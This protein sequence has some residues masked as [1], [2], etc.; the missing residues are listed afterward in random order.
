V[1]QE[2]YKCVTK[3]V[4]SCYKRVTRVLQVCLYPGCVIFAFSRPGTELISS[5][6]TSGGK[7]VD[8]PVLQGCYKGVTRVLQG[9]YSDVTVMLQGC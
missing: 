5:C 3:V 7:P 8:R 9:C 2:C 1:I 6:C 4:Q